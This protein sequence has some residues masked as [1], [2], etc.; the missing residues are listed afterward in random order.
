[1]MRRLTASRKT[2]RTGFQNETS[3]SNIRAA[4]T[5]AAQLGD[6]QLNRQ[7]LIPDS[8][9]N[10]LSVKVN[11]FQVQSRRLSNNACI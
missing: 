4:G 7:H 9:R 8:S 1:M 2:S 5:I 3:R 11:E 10:R 6:A